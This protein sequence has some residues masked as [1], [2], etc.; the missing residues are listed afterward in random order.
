L[1]KL[2]DVMVTSPHLDRDISDL[3]GLVALGRSLW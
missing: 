1:A 2:A 3:A